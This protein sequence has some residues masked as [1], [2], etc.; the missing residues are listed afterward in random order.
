[1]VV[2]QYINNN[3]YNSIT[4][5]KG[6]PILFTYFTSFNNYKSNRMSFSPSINKGFEVLGGQ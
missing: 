5:A 3:V 4:I 1:M 6:Y 2:R